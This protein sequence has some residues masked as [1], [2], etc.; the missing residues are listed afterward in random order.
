M[1]GTTAKR[2]KHSEKFFSCARSTACSVIHRPA[3]I[4]CIARKRCCCLL[5]ALSMRTATAYSPAP[6]RAPR[7]LARSRRYVPYLSQ[8]VLLSTATSVG[9]TQHP[10]VLV[11]IANGSEEI[12][13]VT[14][15]DVLVRAACKVTVASV[16]QDL[17]VECSRMVK[18]VADCPISECVD[19]QWDAVVLPGGMPGAT[20]LYESEHLKTILKEQVRCAVRC[21]TSYE[22]MLLQRCFIRSY[23]MLVIKADQLVNCCVLHLS[24]LVYTQNKHHKLI[25]AICASP[26]VV[27]APLGILQ[28]RVATCYPAD[29][30]ISA[31]PKADQSAGL[32]VV[33]DQHCIQHCC[34]AKLLAQQ[35]VTAATVTVTA[36]L[37]K[38]LLSVIAVISHTSSERTARL[39]SC[40]F[41]FT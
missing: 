19:K 9:S 3:C 39:Q 29:K 24:T 34:T 36:L 20:H 16:S 35:S 15:I 4:E 41:Y 12:E 14:I 11:P 21:C 27:L 40:S 6:H 7:A 2:G 22:L 30:F 18:L 5:L 13:A 23:H 25:G 38:R 8:H 17:Q 28:G 1:S 37:T 26:A 10:R 31:L 32:R 33:R